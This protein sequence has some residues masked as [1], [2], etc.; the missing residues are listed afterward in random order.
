MSQILS[1]IFA[2]HGYYGDVAQLARALAWHARG[3][4]FES[5]YLHNRLMIKRQSLMRLLVPVGIKEAM[6]STLH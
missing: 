5:P 4:G 6:G 1:P 2:A 3:Q